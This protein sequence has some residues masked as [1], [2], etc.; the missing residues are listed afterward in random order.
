[1]GI[2]IHVMVVRNATIVIPEMDLGR[3]YEWFSKLRYEENEYGYLHW[4]YNP[5]DEAIPPEV[6]AD[7]EKGYWGLKFCNVAEFVNWF[8]KYRPDIDAGWIRKKDAWLLDKKEIVP[9]SYC[10]TLEDDCIVADWEFR[11]FPSTCDYAEDIVKEIESR[12][13]LNREQSYLVFYFDN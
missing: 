13:F 3:S 10:D 6:R 12:P 5:E 1:M 9:D 8:Y 2:D 7:I 11:E 4:S